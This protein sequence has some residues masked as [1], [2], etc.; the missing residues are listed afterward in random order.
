MARY[1]H[2]LICNLL[3][4]HHHQK[5]A[6]ATKFCNFMWCVLFRVYQHR[7][8]SD[9]QPSVPGGNPDSS[10]SRH[11]VFQLYLQTSSSAAVPPAR[12]GRFS[13]CLYF[14]YACHPQTTTKWLLLE[15]CLGKH[16]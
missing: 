12:I 11:P 4:Q 14:Q 9:F 3:D 13:P 10:H 6:E 2:F 7:T 15:N 1:F 16:Y 8:L 5:K